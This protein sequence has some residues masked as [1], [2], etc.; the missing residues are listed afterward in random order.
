MTSMTQ[1]DVWS[2][3]RQGV[4]VLACQLTRFR[5]VIAPDG[6]ESGVQRPEPVKFL[7]AVIQEIVSQRTNASRPVAL[8][9]ARLTMW[10]P[11]LVRTELARMVQR[12][13]TMHWT[14]VTWPELHLALVSSAR[15]CA[16]LVLVAMR[17]STLEVTDPE[18]HSSLLV[19]GLERRPDGRQARCA[20]L[21]KPNDLAVVALKCER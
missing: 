18:R 3:K 20:R 5:D 17:R 14:G 6:L 4:N 2:I 12:S 13:S 19:A 11:I 16:L 1:N 7:D 8:R 10:L 15:P 9:V 21:C